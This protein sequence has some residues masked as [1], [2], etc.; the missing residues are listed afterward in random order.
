MLINTARGPLVDVD[1][2]I[3]ALDLGQLGGAAL[4]VVAI[5]PLPQE[6]RLI[7]R[8]RHPHPA[9]RVLF[10]RGARGAA[11]EMRRRCGRVLSGEAPIYPV[12]AT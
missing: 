6:S 5:E 4:D 11:D 8:Q 12:K 3:A 2:L 7:W 1:A 9:Y 10:G